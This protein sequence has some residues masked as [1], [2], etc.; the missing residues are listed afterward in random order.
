MLIGVPKEMHHDDHRVTASPQTAER[1]LKLG[2]TVLAE[3]STGGMANITSDAFP[4]AGAKVVTDG[5]GSMTT[6]YA[7]VYNPL[8]L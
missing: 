1:L 2:H 3:A 8:F 4:E 5:R 6:G 7:G